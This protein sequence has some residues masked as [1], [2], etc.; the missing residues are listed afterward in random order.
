MGY[1][2]YLRALLEPMRLYRLDA[3]SISGA[4]LCAAGQALDDASDAIEAM[5]QESR[6]GTAEGQGLSKWEQLF[7]RCPPKFTT[8]S[9]RTSLFAL[10]RINDDCFTLEA[11]NRC[12]CGCGIRAVAAETDTPQT[13]RI[14]FP[15]IAGI[16][17]QIDRIQEI[18]CDIVPCH[19]A[20]DFYYHFMT[21]GECAALG[22]TWKSVQEAEHTWTSFYVAVRLPHGGMLC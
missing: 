9:R 16:P 15:D 20:I 21:W 8:D 11:V 13:I 7:S 4:E 14:Y 5:E 19:L 2:D 18:I 10:L 17:E 6:I 1:T 22:H 3:E 12:I